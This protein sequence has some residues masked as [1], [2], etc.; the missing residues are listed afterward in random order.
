M[1]APFRPR[2]YSA[3]TSPLRAITVRDLLQLQD[4]PKQPLEVQ[5]RV[6]SFRAMKN[7]SFLDLDDGSS[8]SALKVVISHHGK[9]NPV[10]LK[11]GQSVLVRDAMWKWTP[12]RQQ[13]FELACQPTDVQVLGDVTE[14]YPLQKKYVS[15]KHL[16]QWPL[17][18]HRTQY[19]GGLMRFRSHIEATLTQLLTQEGIYKVPPPVLT[20]GDCEGAGE[21][22]HVEA[23]NLRADQRKY[24]GTD[25]YLTV[26]AQ[27]HLEVIALAL[28]R[29]WALTP[30]F[31]AEESDTSRHLSEFWMLEAELC[32]VQEVTQLTSFVQKLIQ[33]LARTLI[34]RQDE[35]L[36]AMVPQEGAE[37]RETVLGRWQSLLEQPWH[38]ITYTDA[39]QVLQRQHAISPFV[40]E[41]NWGAALQS[42]HE[43]WLAGT[44][45]GGPVFVTDY[46]RECKAFYMRVND[47]NKTFACFDLLFPEMGEVMG[48]SVREERYDVLLR[49]MTSRNMN[50]AE[51]D[52]YLQLRRQGTAPHGGFGLGMERLI[53]W[54]YGNHNVR[55]AIGFYRSATSTIEL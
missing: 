3:I 55:D 23:N 11:T 16:R 22:F 4:A 33:E 43:K 13:A 27:M 50:I 49:E 12:E 19:L 31:R 1:L 47:D 18:K 29:V 38:T 42:E 26:S 36:P 2:R 34:Q 21:L 35:L 10:L 15:L 8:K 28:G 51:L 44:H 54:L 45:Y 37:S 14:E 20:S 52:W 40:H 7:A 48:G 24:F 30:C 41:P 9:P 53:S 25:A 46:P 17:W 6:R 39:I 5:G 32:F